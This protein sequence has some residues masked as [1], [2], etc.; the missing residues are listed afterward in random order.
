MYNQYISKYK[1]Q[2]E[3]KR[4]K[5]KK[6]SSTFI[7]K[8]IFILISI[9]TLLN[10]QTPHNKM[11]DLHSNYIIDLHSNYIIDPHSNYL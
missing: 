11:I 6:K 4:E 8:I 1:Q 5:E 7:N 10:T 2:K 3:K 9:C